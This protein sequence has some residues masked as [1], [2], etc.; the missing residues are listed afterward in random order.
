MITNNEA[1]ENF[2]KG[3]RN[4][5]AFQFCQLIKGTNSD[6]QNNHP[7]HLNQLT[8]VTNVIGPSDTTNATTTTAA[9][10]ATTISASSSD[11]AI[12]RNLSSLNIGNN[13]TPPIL[14][15]SPISS[16]SL[17]NQ[18]ITSTTITQQQKQQQQIK[19]H[20]KKHVNGDEVAFNYAMVNLFTGSPRK[21][22]IIFSDLLKR[23]PRNP[24]LWLRLAESM[25]AA[26]RA[27][28]SEFEHIQ[29]LSHP[30]SRDHLIKTKNRPILI[31][32]N[33][34]YCPQQ[35]LQQSQVSSNRLPANFLVT[36]KSYLQKSLDLIN[37]YNDISLLTD[38]I[39]PQY[40]TNNATIQ[41]HTVANDYDQQQQQQISQFN[42]AASIATNN[43]L[44]PSGFMTPKHTMMPNNNSNKSPTIDSAK[45]SPQ[46]SYANPY[47]SISRSALYHLRNKV[48]LNLAYVCLCMGEPVKALT[49]TT[50]CLKSSPQGYEKVM[51]SL[52]HAEACILASR[53]DE[54][55]QF[56]N[57]E[58]L[59][60]AK[61]LSQDHPLNNLGCTERTVYSDEMQRQCDRGTLATII[62]Y[63]L[64]V[65]YAAKGEFNN[66]EKILM[67]SIQPT[68]PNPMQLIICL[69]YVQ[70]QQGQVAAATRTIM[71]SLPQ[72]R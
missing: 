70:L 19:V 39:P 44:S 54:A 14:Q 22:S 30:H 47:K 62:T 8:K 53:I 15:T 46:L 51:A 40:N 25:L 4:L 37:E 57:L 16:V 2:L 52:Y 26:E 20:K 59:N 50:L 27:R 28:L 11:E 38:D 65:A 12:I 13:S 34:N 63:N 45:L 60:M 69:L 17:I 23:Y 24:R 32:I 18:S 66:A 31:K 55:I 43:I 33:P 72:F 10:S 64:S 3:K 36:I 58:I 35:L 41:R 68:K 61:S 48:Q 5:A 1:V 71:S 29:Q 56:L 9:A 7:H 67:R 21:A 42:P 6:I 49:Y